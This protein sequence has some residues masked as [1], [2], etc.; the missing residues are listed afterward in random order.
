M[1]QETSARTANLNSE[2]TSHYRWPWLLLSLALLILTLLPGC[3]AHSGAGDVSQLLISNERHNIDDERGEVLIYG[4]L[5]N[6]GPGRFPR[7][8]VHAT[9]WSRGG[10][11]AGENSVF[12]ENLQPRE[13]R[14]FALKVTGHA[15]VADLDLQVRIPKGP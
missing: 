14:D 13:N 2:M 1:A 3:R 4:R 11:K 10:E 7:V 8:E 6:T 5:A 15:R 12:L 9:L